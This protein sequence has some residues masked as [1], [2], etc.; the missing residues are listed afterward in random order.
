ML[1]GSLF[2]DE[3][4]TAATI[5][6]LGLILIGSWIAAEGRAPWQRRGAPQAEARAAAAEVAQE[7]LAEDLACDEP[8]TAPRA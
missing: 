4:I 3:P 5:A 6:G 7:P 1:Y 8:L 2:L